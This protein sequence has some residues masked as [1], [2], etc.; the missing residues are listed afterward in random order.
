MRIALSY[1]LEWPQSWRS[2]GTF[3][4]LLAEAVRASDLSQN[5]H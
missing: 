3:A 1:P 2:V 4:A 5:G